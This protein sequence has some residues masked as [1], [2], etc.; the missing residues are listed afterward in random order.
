MEG[1]MGIKSGRS[2]RPALTGRE[3]RELAW[4]DDEFVL[5]ATEFV[6]AVRELYPTAQL[7][8]VNRKGKAAG[9]VA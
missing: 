6:L 9:A 3:E 8:G 2:W 5:E 4:L 1:R 7:V